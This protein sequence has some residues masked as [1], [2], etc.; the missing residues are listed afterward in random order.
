MGAMLSAIVSPKSYRRS[1][2]SPLSC[3]FR[4]RLT[5]ML[6]GA[7]HGEHENLYRENRIRMTGAEIS[8]AFPDP[9]RRSRFWPPH[10]EN[11]HVEQ[12]DSWPSRLRSPSSP[13]FRRLL[14][15]EPAGTARCSTTA[16]APG[17]ALTATNSRGARSVRQQRNMRRWRAEWRP[18][19]LLV[20]STGTQWSLIA[21][22]KAAGSTP[23]R[24]IK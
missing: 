10:K 15:L 16:R 21:L 6:I 7:S 11:D 20:E 18:S 14:V 12:D 9:V 5:L 4:R 24:A 17:L 13:S 19:S 1:A 2:T 22:G 8:A 23:Q 3:R